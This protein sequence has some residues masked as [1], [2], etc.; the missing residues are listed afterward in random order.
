MIILRPLS[1]PPPPLPTVTRVKSLKIFG[2]ILLDSLT[3]TAHID[4]LTSTCSSAFYAHIDNLTSTCSS[5]FYAHI[6]NLTSTCS[7][8]F[9][10]IR[11]LK[12]HGVSSS[13]ICNI[14]KTTAVAKLYYASLSWWGFTLA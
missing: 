8:S 14:T 5:A 12:T 11:K 2:I 10:A 3:L 7:S 6:D 4:N 1:I 13:S 9:Y